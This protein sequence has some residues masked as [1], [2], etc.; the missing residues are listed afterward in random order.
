MTNVAE[1]R[2]AAAKRFILIVN[3]P[4][5][6]VTLQEATYG[7]DRALAIGKSKKSRPEIFRSCSIPVCFL[8]SWNHSLDWNAL[9]NDLPWSLDADRQTDNTASLQFSGI[10]KISEE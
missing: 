6:T 7:I 1:P 3:S 8:Q 4:P 5:K 2:R 9:P 10:V